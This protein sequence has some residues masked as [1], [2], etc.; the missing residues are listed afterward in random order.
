M[1]SLTKN[2]PSV[3]II[4][5]LCYISV[6]SQKLR[7]E[8]V[9]ALSVET[10]GVFEKLLLRVP[11]MSVLEGLKA[12]SSM[13]RENRY[14]YTFA[15]FNGNGWDHHRLDSIGPKRYPSFVTSQKVRPVRLAFE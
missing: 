13:A 2:A 11:S 6:S 5:E 8:R 7:A 4:K 12:L 14:W 1:A 10:G 9:P 3:I 15:V